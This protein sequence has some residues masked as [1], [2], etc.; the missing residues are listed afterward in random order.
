MNRLYKKLLGCMVAV[1][2][3]ACA[4]SAWAQLTIQITHGVS[5]PIPIGL[6]PFGSDAL[7]PVDV[8]GVINSDLDRSG[9]FVGLARSNML[10]TPTT[11]AAVDFAQWR[12]V[13]TD[14]VVIGRVVANGKGMY[15]VEFELFNVVTAERLLG[16]ALPATVKNLRLVAHQASDMI[17]EKILGVPGAFATQIAYV[18]VQGT[19]RSRRWRLVIAD[20]D[21]EMP[22]TVLE[23]KF[24]IMSPSWAPDGERLAYVSFEGEASAVYV[25]TLLTGARDR[26]SARAG[27]NGAPAFSPDGKRLAL[28][29]SQSDGN[30]DVFVLDLAARTTLRVT[31]DPAIDTEPS[32][33][34]DGRS[35]YFTSDRSGRPQIYKIN[36]SAGAQAQRVTFEG[37][38]NARPRVSP[39]GTLLAV[40]TLDQ[41]VYRIA[42]VEAAT[43][44]SR[45]LS[46]GRLDEAPS[47]APNGQTILYSARGAGH[48]VLETA[49]IDG[50]V[51]S[52][53]SALDADVREPAWS[54]RVA[55]R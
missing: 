44:R 22:R 7:L 46:T 52:R 43:G 23:S 37:N 47:F 45:V 24:P 31:D 15:R 20:S 27:I 51:T 16:F 8:A 35:L 3:T 50:S 34:P 11:A 33:A 9:R 17:Y 39:D 40:V 14:Y 29:L 19:P 4:P 21:G 28:A 30:V 26:V 36:L 25:Q 41:G 53:I 49:A 12:L 18:S 32:W 10:Q 38:Y 2:L 6:V 55:T 42:S 54:P 5:A 13:K 1:G 48:G